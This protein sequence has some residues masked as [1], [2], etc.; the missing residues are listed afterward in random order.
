MSWDTTGTDPILV[1]AGAET[2]ERVI[3][4]FGGSTEWF[5]RHIIVKSYEVRGLSAAGAEAYTPAAVDSGT[6]ENVTRPR[7]DESGQHVCR[8]DERVMDPDDGT[9]HNGYQ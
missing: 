3:S 1:E 4:S 9:Y 7:V 2:I 6:I 5:H 8:W